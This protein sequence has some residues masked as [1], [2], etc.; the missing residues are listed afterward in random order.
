[1]PNSSESQGAG[2][3]S[4]ATPTKTDTMNGTAVSVICS[5]GTR[6]VNGSGSALCV[7]GVWVPGAEEIGR[8]APLGELVG[9]AA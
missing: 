5:V 6:L 8:C 2:A 3:V 4:S 7:Q 9:V 1:M